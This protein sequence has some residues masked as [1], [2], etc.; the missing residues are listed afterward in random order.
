MSNFDDS[1]YWFYP[2][3]IPHPSLWNF[4]EAPLT[5]PVISTVGMGPK[6]DPG[7]DGHMQFGRPGEASALWDDSAPYDE[8]VFVV[9][10][11]NIYV[12]VKPVPTGIDIHNEEYWRQ[13]SAGTADVT[14]LINRLNSLEQA[15]HTEQL[16]R[17]SE[18][19]SLSGRIDDEAAARRSGDTSIN[20]RLSD[21]I[22]ARISGD[23]DLA[24]DLSLEESN[25]ISGDGN[26]QQQIDERYTKTEADSVFER[27]SY[28]ADDVL[29]CI[30]DGQLVGYSQENPS[31]IT[32][33][34][35]YLGKALGFSS[36]NIFKECA[37]NSGFAVGSPTFQQMLPTIVTQLGNAE[38]TANDV[39]LVVV[40]GGVNDL[41]QLYN[42]QQQNPSGVFASAV[43][44]FVQSAEQIFPNAEIH[45][46]PILLGCYGFSGRVVTMESEAALSVARQE[47]ERTDLIKAF[48]HRNVWTWNYDGNDD[49]ISTDWLHLLAKGQKVAGESMALEIKGGD[50]TNWGHEFP[51]DDITGTTIAYGSRYGAN[52]SYRFW[53]SYSSQ[54]RG[55][56]NVVFWVHPRYCY[57]DGLIYLGN[58]AGGNIALTY[59]R[60][61]QCWS[62]FSPISN[63]AI[64]GTVSYNIQSLF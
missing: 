39:K 12:S 46:F 51:I 27:K 52:V 11:D 15:V 16:D 58:G 48:V 60:I 26:L 44:S 53:D 37:I 4:E 34:D 38:K 49:G 57:Q 55:G 32:A 19:S 10:G 13:F 20:G 30:G 40:S 35:H 47:A 25:R 59:D 1:Q 21:E 17:A 45:V 63:Q 41:K 6:G 7:E 33:W 18:D 43:A 29:V 24:E 3:P 23:A 22:Q 31:G 54:E 9:N 42:G 36:P 8:G 5:I 62:T 14:D 2:K 64:H 50:A 28:S 56:S 61:Q